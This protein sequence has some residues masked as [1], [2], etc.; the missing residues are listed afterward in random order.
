MAKRKN[1]KPEPAPVAVEEPEPVVPTRAFLLSGIPMKRDDI[2]ASLDTAGLAEDMDALKGEKLL[3][4][5]AVFLSRQRGALVDAIQEHEAWDEHLDE[6]TGEEVPDAV[7]ETLKVTQLRTI[8]KNLDGPDLSDMDPAVAAALTEAR[9]KVGGIQEK[10][11]A[12]T[13]EAAAIKVKLD[14]VNAT[15]RNLRAQLRALRS[16]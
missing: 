12:A 13:V 15:R 11:D 16:V 10:L 14:A 1:T 9:A 7:D 5:R 2:I 8:L 3:A 4:L 6:E